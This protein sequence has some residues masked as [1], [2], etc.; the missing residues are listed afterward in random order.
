MIVQSI[1]AAVLIVLLAR[2]PAYS[3]EGQWAVLETSHFAVYYRPGHEDLAKRAGG[4]AEAALARTAPRLWGYPSERIPVYVYHNRREFIRDTGLPGSKLVV[5]VAYSRRGLM[6]VD[7][8]QYFASLPPVIA[9]ELVH[10]LIDRR[11]GSRVYGVPLWLNEGLAEMLSGADRFTSRMVL[12]QAAST[13]GLLTFSSLAEQFPDGPLGE[14]AYCQSRA[15]VEY[16]SQRGNA[17]LAALDRIAA[18]SSADE[19]FARSFGA[20]IGDLELAWRRTLTARRGVDWF[21]I[22]DTVGVALLLL[23]G[24]YLAYKGIQRRR[25]RIIEEWEAEEANP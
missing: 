16:L 25:R 11:M 22:A 18:G 19:A 13:G 6:R 8:S 10:V 21:S 4:D 2:V 23:A 9:H 24:L 15:F 1:G 14:L 12:N 3:D 17:L 7:G 5:G 20:T